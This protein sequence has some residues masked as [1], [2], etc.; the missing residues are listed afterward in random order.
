MGKHKAPKEYDL[1][2]M[3][4][5]DEND[6]LAKFFIDWATNINQPRCI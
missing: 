1:S 4:D 5:V 6:E 2:V 3:D